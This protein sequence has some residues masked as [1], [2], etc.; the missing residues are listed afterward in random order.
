MKILHTAD[1]HL[2]DRLNHID[3]TADLRRAVERVADYCVQRDVDVLLVAGDLFSERCRADGLRDS[4]EHLN[5]VFRPFLERGGT[6]VAI[7]GNHD[8]ET[9]CRTLVHAMALATPGPGAAGALLPGGRFYLAAEPTFLRL[10]DRAGTAVQFV[11]MPYP[12]DHRY[13]D[14]SSQN[15]TTLE[16]KHRALQAAFTQKLVQMQQH[17]AFDARL[18][19]VLAAH[20]HVRGSALPTLFRITE[21]EDILVQASDLPGPWS[22]VA[23]G[24]IH[25][26]QHLKGLPHVRYSGSIE[27]LDMG[28][29]RDVK[30]VT[31]LE[32]GPG[33]LC[34]PAEHLP[35]EATEFVDLTLADARQD[36]ARLREEFPRGSDGLVRLQVHFRA[37]DD[38][39]AVLRELRT[40]FPRFYQIQW[41]D[42]SAP[43]NPGEAPAPGQRSVRETVLDYL[44]GQLAEHG[45]RAAVLQ[46]AEQL[47]LEEGA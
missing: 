43:A 4:I 21:H 7:T 46:L 24:H 33:G 44:G 16:E 29:R 9:F 1:W 11:L 35:L 32:V 41:V 42:A 22:Y 25:Q 8:N 3:R 10:Q 20:V 37:G 47:L 18:P 5:R 15:Y 39:N 13:L 38:L 14:E 23:L 34:G 19:S 26:P 40:L 31:L 6:I 30:G 28:E 12:T 27:R 36:L 17:P 2:G 45:E